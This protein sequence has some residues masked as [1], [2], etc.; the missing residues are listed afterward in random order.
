MQRDVFKMLN[1]AIF[2][3]KRNRKIIV[4]LTTQNNNSIE[5]SIA[6]KETGKIYGSLDLNRRDGGKPIVADPDVYLHHYRA[7]LDNDYYEF[8]I[9]L[10]D[11]IEEMSLMYN[12]VEI[13]GFINKYL[14]K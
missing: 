14:E 2:K 5:I 13:V 1:E 7:Y 4:M 12:A 6:R 11:L 8:M 10:L 3:I 9:P